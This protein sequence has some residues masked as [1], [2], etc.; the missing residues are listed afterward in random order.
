MSK[1]AKT[2]PKEKLPSGTFLKDIKNTVWEVKN[3]I[4]SGRF[5][6][7]YCGWYIL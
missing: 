4:G 1:K 5:G 7:V 6:Y 2:T 3:N